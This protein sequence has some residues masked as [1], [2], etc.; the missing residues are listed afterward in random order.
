MIK[1]NLGS[2]KRKLKDFINIDNRAECNPDVICDLS[3]GI[4]YEDNTVDEVV[5]IDFIEHLE[6][7]DVLKFMD[8]VYRVLKPGGKFFHRTPSEEGRGAWQDP[9]HKSAWN[10]N[11]WKHYFTDPAY[12]DLYGTVPNFKI[13]QLFDDW[14]DKENKVLHTHCLYEAIK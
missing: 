1:L 10:I 7:Q 4:P 14:T 11:T 12:R 13:L 6:R 8:E 9:M 3:E 5:A 2:G